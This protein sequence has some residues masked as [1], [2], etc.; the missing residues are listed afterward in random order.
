M[1]TNTP[2]PNHLSAVI[3]FGI[4]GLSA[5]VLA[6]LLFVF[7]VLP[8]IQ[9]SY[10]IMQQQEEIFGE[11]AEPKN[12]PQ[13]NVDIQKVQDIESLK[14][15]AGLLEDAFQYDKLIESAEQIMKLATTDEDRAIAHYFY[16]SA[17]AGKK[18]YAL[19]KDY[20]NKALELNPKY[21]NAYNV[22][23]MVA[24]AE[25]ENE[26]SISYAQKALE[27]DPNNSW[28]YN[29]LGI[30]YNY[31]GWTAMSIE[32]FEEAVRLSPNT[33]HYKDNLR[34]AKGQNQG[35]MNQ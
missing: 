35:V 23:S 19:A 4:I 5:T 10:Q 21:A 1:G 24:A 8:K 9:V 6:A 11:S 3:A 22:L 26:L 31:K 20:A 13:T 15:S 32:A 33:S 2:W 29:L 34:R 28:S 27:I 12:A 30:D 17:Y 14:R 7:V 18:E 25:F 16:A